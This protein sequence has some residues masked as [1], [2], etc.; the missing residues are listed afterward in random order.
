MLIGASGIVNGSLLQVNSKQLLVSCTF[1]DDPEPSLPVEGC[2][3][4][5]NCTENNFQYD[6]Y[7]VRNNLTSVVTKQTNVLFSCSANAYFYNVECGN[8]IMLHKPVIVR[9]GISIVNYESMLM[10]LRSEMSSS[11]DTT[12]EA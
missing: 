8:S 1:S 3:V 5:V 6:T 7:I 9:R 11:N 12:G 10:S 4:V 2:Y